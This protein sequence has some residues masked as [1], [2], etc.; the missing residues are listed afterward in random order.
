MSLPDLANGAFEMCGAAANLLNVFRLWRDRRLQGVHWAGTT[1]F[2]A[3]GLWNL[4]YYPALDQWFSFA[5]G[6]AIVLTNAVW[7]VSLWIIVKKRKE[8]LI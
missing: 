4:Y 3:W 5:G 2:T 7:L 6:L 8:T 1:Y